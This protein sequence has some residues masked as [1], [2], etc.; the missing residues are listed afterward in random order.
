MGRGQAIMLVSLTQAPGEGKPDAPSPSSFLPCCLSPNCLSFSRSVC[1]MD[2]QLLNP[3]LGPF[4]HDQSTWQVV[5]AQWL[6]IPCLTL[7]APA[8]PT[9]KLL[10]PLQPC[11]VVS[12]AL[13]LG[14]GN[15]L[16]SRPHLSPPAPSSPH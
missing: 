12:S 16:V 1:L 14:V 15:L 3:E 7:S 11:R 9:V 4:N 6:S 2:L 5:G 10:F 13:L 8:H